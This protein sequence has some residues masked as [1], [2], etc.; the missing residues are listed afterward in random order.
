MKTYVLLYDGFVQFEIIIT[1]LL[2][3]DKSKIIT[4]SL[5]DN[6]VNCHEG[7]KIVADMNVRDVNPEDVDLFLISGGDPDPYEKRADMNDLIRKIHH[8]ERPIA[9]ICGGPGFLAHA[10]I[11]KGKKITHGYADDE[12]EIVFKDSIITDKDVVIDKNIITARGKA[13]V[14]FAIEICK[15]L[16]LRTD[17]EILE[18]VEFFIGKAK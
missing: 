17:T 5:D 10:G 8:L 11:L 4:C 14:E 6:E 3:K 15:E 13:Y 2:L 16:K 12:A 1:L 18:I 7:L 9:A